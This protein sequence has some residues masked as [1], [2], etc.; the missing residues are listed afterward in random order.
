MSRPT[1][2]RK[3]SSANAVEE[4]SFD[5]DARS[6]YLTGFHKRKLQRIKHAQEEAVKKER[7]ERLDQRKRLRE[8]RKEEA[9]KHVETVNALLRTGRGESVSSAEET[10]DPHDEWTG[11][12][13]T[14]ADVALHQQEEYMDEDR[15]TTVTV[16]TVDVSKEGLRPVHDQGEDADAPSTVP[17]APDG[18]RRGQAEGQSRGKRAWAKE[19]PVKPKKKKKKFRY[20]SRAERKVTRGKERAGNKAKAKARRE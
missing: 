18:N 20:E 9:R 12:G 19:K 11:V 1:K 16:E 6:E 2:K 5:F 3:T 15:D 4:I 10:E 17:I 14:P 8:E 7:A 13:D